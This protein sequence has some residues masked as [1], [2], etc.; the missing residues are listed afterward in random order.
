MWYLLQ[1]FFTIHNLNYVI[2]LFQLQV[3]FQQTKIYEQLV[4]NK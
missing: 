4:K 3:D 2:K 1:V